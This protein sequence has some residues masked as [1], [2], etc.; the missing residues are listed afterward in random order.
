MERVFITGASGFVG[1]YLINILTKENKYEIYGTKL[2][3]EKV[4]IENVK[5]YD[6][7]LTSK[8]NVESIIKETCP[9]IVFHLAALSSVK[10]SWENPTNTVDININGTINLLEAIRKYNDKCKILLVG[11]S[12]EYG[13]TFSKISNPKES[14]ECHPQNMYAITKYTQGKLG[15]LY[16]NVYKMNIKMT[17]SFNHFGPGQSP[18]FV[19]SDFC[20]QAAEISLGKKE[21]I[22]KVGNL[23]VYRD[24]SDVRDVVNA[25]LEIVNNGTSGEIYNV[26]SSHSYQIRKILDLIISISGEDIKV[27]VDKEKY[28]PSDI[29]KT[30]ANIDKLSNELNYIHKYNIKETIIE[31]FNYWKN[32]INNK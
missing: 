7:D 20:K 3:G 30:V 10:L 14:D 15:E 6:L 27:V 1:K 31:T 2:P 16:S 29:K 26:G 22:I 24:F 21:K 19:I 32:I 25:Y 12:E 11:S 8:K 23:D 5:L 18:N 9:D 4:I 13:S 17:R 28:R